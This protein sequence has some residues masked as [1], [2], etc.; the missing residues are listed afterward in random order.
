M[1]KP[2]QIVTGAIGEPYG[3]EKNGT[4]V[5]GHTIYALCDDG[6][7][8]RLYND[9]WSHLDDIPQ[10][11]PEQERQSYVRMS[12]G[13]VGVLLNI[14]VAAHRVVKRHDAGERPVNVESLRAKLSAL[15]QNWIEAHGEL[16]QPVT[17]PD[18]V[19]ALRELAKAEEEYRNRY[20]SADYSG[21]TT[22][23]M[24]D[25]MRRAGDAARE[26]LKRI[27]APYSSE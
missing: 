14:A 25:K 21:H 1:R 16:E 20:T 2:V 13:E 24:L 9:G 15:G 19:A 10:D 26:V 3:D 27:D 11:E 12:A 23:L 7:I 6:S 18:V 17:S 22:F 5:I 4:E 8:W